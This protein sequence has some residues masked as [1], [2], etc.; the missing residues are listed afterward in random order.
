M[1][2]NTFQGPDVRCF[3]ILIHLT[4]CDG[5]ANPNSIPFMQFNWELR[6]NS[7]IIC[8]LYRSKRFTRRLMLPSV[9][10]HLIRNLPKP[11]PL[12]RDGIWLSLRTNSVRRRSLTA[13]PH[14][15]PSL[16][17]RLN[18]CIRHVLM[19]K[20]F[21]FL[22][23]FSIQHQFVNKLKWP[24][25]K[26]MRMFCFNRSYSIRG[27]IMRN[28]DRYYDN[29]T[30]TL[31]NKFKSR[32]IIKNWFAFGLNGQKIVLHFYNNAYKKLAR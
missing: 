10:N 17:P 6:K 21:S 13:R 19:N 1:D 27:S 15:W 8:F 2:Y 26:M 11:H 23:Y 14:F 18:S 7:I 20:M 16:R 29:T 31:Y 3:L 24:F 5:R 32:K 4:S 12:R 9:L 30:F 25:C 22:F 28:D